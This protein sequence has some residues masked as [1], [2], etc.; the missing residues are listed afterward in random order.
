M[1]CLSAAALPADTTQQPPLTMSFWLSSR[2]VIVDEPLT[3]HYR[4]YNHTQTMVRADFPHRDIF[5]LVAADPAAWLNLECIGPDGL[6]APAVTFTN[7]D[8]KSTRLNTRH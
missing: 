3:L 1:V 5:E 2:E 7:I 4:V 6:P 8:R